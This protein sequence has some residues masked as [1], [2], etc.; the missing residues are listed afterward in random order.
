MKREKGNE[1]A[2]EEETG[3]EIRDGGYR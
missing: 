3:E 1:K 2:V